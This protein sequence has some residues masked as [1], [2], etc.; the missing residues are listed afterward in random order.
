MGPDLVVVVLKV[1]DYALW[2]GPPYLVAL[3]LG[4]LLQLLWAQWRS[5]VVPVGRVSD[6]P[7]LAAP[8]AG[9][10]RS[11]LAWDLW[12]RSL[13]Y[14]LAPAALV[15][16]LYLNGLLFVARLGGTLLVS[17]L[18]V[19]GVS[20]LG[21]RRGGV[22]G[23][24]R[25]GV[26]GTPSG[27]VPL[28]PR[29]AIALPNQL[30]SWWALFRQQLDRE[31]NRFLLGGL[32]G[33]LILAW[34]PGVWLGEQLAG[35]TLAAALLGAVLGL[36][37]PLNGGAVLLVVVALMTRGAGPAAVVSLLVAA[38]L[39]NWWDARRLAQQYGWPLL[40]WY[41]GLGVVGATLLGFALAQVPGSARLSNY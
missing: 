9:E 1:R 38:P 28:P 2:L 40:L 17:A 25:G 39:L 41:L 16:P 5:R 30:R 35:A 31:L 15:L 3:A 8:G 36:I 24:S 21:Q 4:A 23:P 32:L 29:P 6:P 7:A 27:I 10:R 11:Q 18:I 33:G 13:C 34:P 26:P 20:L 37:L 14:G 12:V 19:V 22:P